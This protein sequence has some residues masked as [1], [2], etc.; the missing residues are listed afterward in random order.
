MKIGSNIRLLSKVFIG[1]HEDPL[2]VRYTIFR[3]KAWGVFVHKL[4]RSDHD[5]ALHDHPWSF[6]SLVLKRGYDEVIE[7]EHGNHR[8][9][10]HSAGSILLRPAQWKH[11]VVL[12][13]FQ[14]AWTLVF[15]GPRTR[16]WGFFTPDGW[17]WWRKYNA[18]KAFCE[19]EPIHLS[20]KD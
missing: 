14:P 17:C 10:T 8:V 3:C 6:I 13:N 11:R 19:E 9:L 18:D 7:G 1:G 20:G 2:L 4:C 12:T 16:K 15:V 5:R